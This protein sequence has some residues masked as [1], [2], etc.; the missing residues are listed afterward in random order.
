[1][2]EGKKDGMNL[3]ER[4]NETEEIWKKSS[5]DQTKRMEWNGQWNGMKE[6]RNGTM[7]WRKEWME[8]HSA[9]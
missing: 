7:E 6:G 9:D 4:L 1:M 8:S 5:T 3:E 2:E